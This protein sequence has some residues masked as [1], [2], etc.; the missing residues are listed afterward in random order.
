MSGEHLQAMVHA[1]IDAFVVARKRNFYWT[2]GPQAPRH[3]EK[4][5][6]AAASPSAFEHSRALNLA[7]IVSTSCVTRVSRSDFAT[8]IEQLSAPKNGL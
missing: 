3:T 4:R 1:D 6:L 8:R 2:R 7:H 5:T